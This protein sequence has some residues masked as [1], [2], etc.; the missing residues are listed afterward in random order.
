MGLP[1]SLSVPQQALERLEALVS[2]LELHYCLLEWLV[3]HCFCEEQQSFVVEADIVVEVVTAAAAA[4]S[5][6]FQIL[7]GVSQWLCH[8]GRLLAV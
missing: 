3:P 2:S 5:L 8:S 7:A 6:Q 4:L 1:V